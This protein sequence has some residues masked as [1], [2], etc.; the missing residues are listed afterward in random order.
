MHSKSSLDTGIRCVGGGDECR[1]LY[2]VVI[3]VVVGEKRED[4]IAGYITPFHAQAEIAL[5]GDRRV[6]S[7]ENH[8]LTEFDAAIHE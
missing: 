2:L 4:V 7:V 1:R 5:H 3:A 6:T 8:H